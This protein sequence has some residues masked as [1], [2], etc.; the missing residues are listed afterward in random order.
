MRHHPDSY[1]PEISCLIEDDAAAPLSHALLSVTPR[2]YSNPTRHVVLSEDGEDRHRL[3]SLLV[4]A[5]AKHNVLSQRQRRKKKNPSGDVVLKP[6]Q[7]KEHSTNIPACGTSLGSD[8]MV[9][10]KES[11]CAGG[12]LAL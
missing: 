12:A 2:Y 1:I 10:N 3:A 11:F 5:T 9:N 8:L 6:P 7:K 4:R